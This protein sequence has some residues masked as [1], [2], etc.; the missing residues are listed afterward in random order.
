M[1]TTVATNIIKMLESVPDQLQDDVV[2]HMRNYIENILDEAKWDNSFAKN[3][4]NLIAA[5]RQA[6]REIAIGKATPM[7]TNKL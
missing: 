4:D 6:R 3:Q 7:D 2:E 1:N 5:A